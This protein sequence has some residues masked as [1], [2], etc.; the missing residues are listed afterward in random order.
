MKLSEIVKELCL[1]LHLPPNRAQELEELEFQFD[2]EM[3]LPKDEMVELLNF[4]LPGRLVWILT[5]TYYSQ[6][7]IELILAK[8]GV[9]SIC[10]LFVSSELGL[11]KD[12]LSL[13][14]FIKEKLHNQNSGKYI[15]VG[16]NVVSD[17]QL[18]GDLGLS[19]FHILHPLDKW[20]A[21]GY[22]SVLKGE[23]ALDINHILKWGPL[24][25]K[26]G[27]NPFLGE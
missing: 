10:E 24:V 21:L 25:S 22:P 2:Y 17:A 18:P 13:W 26:I 19:T 5:D 7:Q 1:K 15:H 27:R 20:H 14:H 8:V 23:G 16:D 6:Q 9:P 4:L 11:R 12:N 3:I